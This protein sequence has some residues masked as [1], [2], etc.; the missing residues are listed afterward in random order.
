MAFFERPCRV[1][2]E[3][4]EKW[5]YGPKNGHREHHL[6][7]GP[8]NTPF[9]QRICLRSRCFH[10]T[11]CLRPRVSLVQSIIHIYVPPIVFNF[12]LYLKHNVFIHQYSGLSPH[13]IRKTKLCAALSVMN[14]L[15]RNTGRTEEM[16]QWWDNM[17]K[18][19]L[20]HVSF[21]VHGGYHVKTSRSGC[22]WLKTAI[23]SIIWMGVAEIHPFEQFMHRERRA[24]LF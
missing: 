1:P 24:T 18:Y 22:T 11:F 12:N 15:Q 10:R 21:D 3:S 17:T 6:N 8:G 9:A 16:K 14:V 23:E 4:S 2:H 5:L 13:M 7:R 19:A 20:K